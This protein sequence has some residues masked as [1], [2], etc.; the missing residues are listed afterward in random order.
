[1]HPVLFHFCRGVDDQ[2]NHQEKPRRLEL[3]CGE[4]GALRRNTFEGLCDHLIH[5]CTWLM[6][7]SKHFEGRVRSA[8]DVCVT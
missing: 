7:L 3:L 6:Y 4:K 8:V 1:M 5:G 2:E